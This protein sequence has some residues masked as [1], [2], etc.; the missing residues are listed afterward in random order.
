MTTGYDVEIITAAQYGFH[1]D[2]VIKELAMKK[3]GL[4][5]GPWDV[6]LC[7]F[8]CAGGEDEPHDDHEW[9]FLTI[10]MSDGKDAHHIT[11]HREDIEKEID[12]RRLRAWENQKPAWP[13]SITLPV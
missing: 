8:E 12:R 6:G 13:H 11:L 2:Y 4:I 9:V 5:G 10:T 1:F 7:V 3:E